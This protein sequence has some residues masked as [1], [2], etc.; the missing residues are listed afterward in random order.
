MS[1]ADGAGL[2]RRTCP[3]RSHI[4]SCTWSCTAIGLQPPLRFIQ[5]SLAGGRAPTDRGMAPISRLS[6]VLVWG[7]ASFPARS[8]ARF[9][10]LTSRS[11]RSTSPPS[12]PAPLAPW[13]CSNRAPDHSAGAALSALPTGA[14]S[15]SGSRGCGATPGRQRHDRA[16]LARV[17]HFRVAGLAGVKRDPNAIA[18]ELTDSDPT[19]AGP[20]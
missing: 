15:L 13:F 4:Q 16:I 17:A 12:A 20:C 14:R 10:C 11:Q 7:E 19:G 1:S 6:L 2:K 18:S 8:S 5:S 9:G 3:H